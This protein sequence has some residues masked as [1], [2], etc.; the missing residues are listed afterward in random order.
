ME[1]PWAS[2]V[3]LTREQQEKQA[4]RRSANFCGFL[5]IAMMAVQKVLSVLLG[6]FAVMGV[7]D[8]S[9]ADYG[10]G[11][12]GY[13]LLNMLLYM[14]FLPVP[15]VTVALITHS[16]VSPFPTR[17]M[18]LVTLVCLMLAGMAMAVLA[19]LATSYFMAIMEGLGVPH[20]EFPDTMEP[21]TTSLWLNVLSTAVVPALVVEMIFRGYFLGALRPHGDGIAVVVSAAVFGL[22]HGNVL[23]I[24]F[25][26]LLGL[27]FGYVVVQ[28]GSIW[29]A[30]LIHFGNNLMSVLLEYGAERY[31][32][33]GQ[34]TLTMGVFTAIC[35]LGVA[36][37]A[38]LLLQRRQNVFKPIG[39]G[40]SALSVGA[41]VRAIVL[42]PALLIALIW[43][44]VTLFVGMVL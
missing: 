12:T 11:N 30:V 42:S 29:P 32:E 38:V 1:Q 23:Q 33:W 14:L 15:A 19:N 17:R 4:V 43:M 39:N 41:R 24:P 3:L 28:T 8:A 22:F 27:V 34:N 31:P 13:Q 40:M 20:P 2:T 6:L 36:A 21:T 35:V 7:L 10:L 5:V 25:A 16:R 9:A 37:T 18:P 44:T 26:F